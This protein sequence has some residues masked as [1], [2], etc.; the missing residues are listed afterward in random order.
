MSETQI[1]AVARQMLEM[2]GPAAIA[3]AS[4]KALSCESDGE[5]EEARE[6]RHIADAMKLMRGPHQ[7]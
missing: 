6:W 3:Q 7:S 1:H 5:S 2:H 4:Q